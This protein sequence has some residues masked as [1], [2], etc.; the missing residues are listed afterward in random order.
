[1]KRNREMKPAGPAES[2]QMP[3]F[4]LPQIAVAHFSR[5]RG[6][7]AGSK[8]TTICQPRQGG[9]EVARSTSSG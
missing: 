3:L 6:Q 5:Q 8:S 7:L 4:N 2:D 1:M 9:A